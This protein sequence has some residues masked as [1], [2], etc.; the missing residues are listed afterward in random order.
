[1]KAL[2]PKD[3]GIIHA[4][5]MHY[6]DIMSGPKKP[7]VYFFGTGQHETSNCQAETTQGLS[8]P[9]ITA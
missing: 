8:L 7:G 1:M 9:Q 5:T 3:E 6:P 4:F 2:S